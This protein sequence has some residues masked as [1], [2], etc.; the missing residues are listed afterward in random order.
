[1]TSSTSAVTA[2]ANTPV[3]APKVQ[4]M[5][6]APSAPLENL[7]NQLNSE[8]KAKEDGQNLSDESVTPTRFTPEPTPPVPAQ[9]VAPSNLGITPPQP[10]PTHALTADA[11]R[12][13]EIL[14]RDYPKVMISLPLYIGEK[15]GI[16][17]DSCSINGYRY[18]V[19]KGVMVWVP[20]PVA[21]IFMDHYNIQM[22]ETETGQDALAHKTG[23]REAAL[24]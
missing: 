16:S 7:Q 4:G 21:R 8:V 5:T 22:G 3:A 2:T 14:N 20:E 9:Q 10:S 11:L 17:E 1:M 24:T 18:V 15:P 13:K 23:D 6:S 19:K 12:T